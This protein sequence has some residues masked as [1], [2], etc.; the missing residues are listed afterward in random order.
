MELGNKLRFLL[1]HDL[2]EDAIYLLKEE[3]SEI[4]KLLWNSCEKGSS[5]WKKAAESFLTEYIK[6]L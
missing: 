2:L 5:K 4:A 6:N 1:S 3:E